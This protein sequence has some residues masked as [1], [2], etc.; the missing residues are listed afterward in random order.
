MNKTGGFLALTL[1][2]VF[3]C[4]V[5]TQA[6]TLTSVVVLTPGA[7]VGSTVPLPVGA[8]GSTILTI[9]VNR[10]AA[11]TIT[12]GSVNFLTNFKFPS[13]VTITGHHIH[14]GAATVNA[15]VVI[16]PSLSGSQTQYPGG[17]GMLNITAGSANA[18]VLKRLLAK[19]SAFYVNLHTSA[20]LA[21]AIRGQV[22]KLTEKLA[23]SVE[24]NTASE[25]PPVTNVTASGTGTITLELTRNSV[26]EVIGGIVTFTI[27][28]NHPANVAFNGLHIHEQVV[29]INGPVVIN[30]GVSNAN[31][32]ISASGR[33]VVN[34]PVAVTSGNP[35]AALKRLI[36]NPTGFYVNIHT[37]ENPG[38]V[39]RGQLTNNFQPPPVILASSNYVL[40]AGGL[41]ST[42]MLNGIGFDGGSAVLVN[43]QVAMT[44]IFPDTR[45][46]SVTI[47]AEA[48]A[49][50]GLLYIQVRR[51]DG[52]RS[53]PILVPVVSGS[54]LS[55]LAAV[56][57]DAAR[58]SDV[59]SPDAI[60]AVF[61]TELATQMAA[62]T[63]Q[64]LPRTLDGT[65]VYVNGVAAQLF[66]VS[67]NQ[68]NL[69]VPGETLTG[70][71]TLV[72]VN[73]NGRVT[74]G[75]VTVGE[76]VPGIFTTQGT[77]AGAPAALA[78]ADGTNFNIILG[79][80]DGTAVAVDAGAF[81]MM[82]GTGFRYGSALPT[83]S[84][85]GVA[86]TPTFSGAQGAFSGLDQ[87]NFQ[88]PA[89][90]AGRGDVDLIMTVDGRAANTVRLKI[91]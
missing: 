56:T 33:G 68:I 14:E 45:E 43:G 62:A 89:S 72:I 76:I 55:L 3:A 87:A 16:N 48:T 83:I 58:Y 80:A 17:A 21:G 51:N 32:I 7:E 40:T 91:K 30:T 26:G 54:N 67:S 46:L 66:Y 57:V 77:G 69:L 29:G 86:V 34:F 38:G 49:S 50:P 70:T 36:A 64:P 75:L 35:L 8:T 53:A 79:N 1:M 22:V 6:E 63:T 52:L 37:P 2:F 84:I 71:A 39:I 15:P 4:A 59:V 60:A 90:L 42:L 13:G 73:R 11:G 47:P 23:V 27:E 44:G 41:Q 74:Q 9:T 28:F 88:I 81:V 31:R 18:E 61:G 12:G 25:N 19:P 20:N 24:M 5:P 10:D 82:F 85:G 65:V 78:S